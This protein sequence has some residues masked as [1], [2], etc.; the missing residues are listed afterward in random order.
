MVTDA[1]KSML[2]IGHDR[3]WVDSLLHLPNSPDF[4]SSDYHLFGPLKA[5]M[6]VTGNAECHAHI[7]HT[8]GKAIF[9]GHEHVLCFT[10][11]RRLDKCGDQSE[12]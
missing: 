10:R 1:Y 12:N 4:V 11:G 2:Y 8:G 9:T 5:I 3:F 6:M 7:C